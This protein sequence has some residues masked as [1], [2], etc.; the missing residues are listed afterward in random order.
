MLSPFQIEARQNLAMFALLFLSP[1]ATGGIAYLLAPPISGNPLEGYLGWCAISALIFYP[2]NRF[3]SWA[4]SRLPAGFR[5]MRAT[6]HRPDQAT[7]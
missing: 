6:L 4:I 7:R 1:W 3:L 5:A 2:L